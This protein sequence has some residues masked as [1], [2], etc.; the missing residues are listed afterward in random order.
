MA[1][2]DAAADPWL[3][4]WLPLA[5]ERAGSAPILELGCGPGG[6]TATLVEAGFRVV[7]IDRSAEAIAAARGRVPEAAAEFHCRDFREP[8]PPAVAAD[9]GVGVVV[10]SLSLH[11]FPWAETRALADRIRATLWP[12][13]VL[14]CRLNSTNDVHS[15]AGG[16]H[17]EI[18]PHYYS[19]NGRQKRF[20]DREA[21]DALFSD[22]WRTLSVEEMVIHRY[23]LPKAAWEVVLE[24]PMTPP[25]SCRPT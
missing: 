6:D 11:Y 19:V 14:L 8:F 22:G 1:R 10:A 15:G 24:K 25:G 20:F 4:R 9:A 23:A 17:P 12:G 5:R 18:E 2:V 16:G 13:G 7:A 21:V 3:G